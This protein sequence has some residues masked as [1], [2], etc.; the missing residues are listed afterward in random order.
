M[1]T[2]SIMSLTCQTNCLCT[3]IT[4]F[5]D[6]IY[7]TLEPDWPPCGVIRSPTCTSPLTPFLPDTQLPPPQAATS[8]SPPPIYQE[9]IE[10]STRRG[11][12]GAGAVTANGGSNTPLSSAS[13][14]HIQRNHSVHGSGANWHFKL[15]SALTLISRNYG[16][17]L[18]LTM[19]SLFSQSYDRHV[20]DLYLKLRSCWVDCYM[21]FCD[22]NLIRPW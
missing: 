18:I 22:K 1:H 5:Q 17:K 3:Y 8:V 10:I 12:S 6:H 21:L 14:P 19:Q 2:L 20:N 15:A 11:G 13:P 4:K 9:I 16:I 7:F